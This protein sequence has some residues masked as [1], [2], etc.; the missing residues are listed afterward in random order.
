MLSDDLDGWDGGRGEEEIYRGSGYMY[1]YDW[2]VL[3]CGRNQ[4]NIVNIEKQQQ[5]EKKN[6]KKKN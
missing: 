2:F 4:H 5:K 3:V 6:V 1:N